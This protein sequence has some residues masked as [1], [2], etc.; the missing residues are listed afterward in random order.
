MHTEDG[1]TGVGWTDAVP[2]AFAITSN[3]EPRQTS[4]ARVVP[5]GIKPILL[6]QDV[7]ATEVLWQQML[8]L[9]YR[10]G[11]ASSGWS[12]S[13]ILASIAATDMALWDAKSKAAG[14]PVWKMLGA[15]ESAIDCY[16]AGGYYRDGKTTQNLADE[17]GRYAEQGFKA[18]KIRV[19]GR[20]IGEDVERVAAVRD[21][22]GA[23]VS[24]MIDANDAYDSETA[25]GAASRYE[26]HDIFWMEEPTRWYEGVDATKRVA[27]R[28]NIPIAGGE[29]AESRWEA[30]ELVDRAGLTFMQF[31]GMKTG[32]PTEW[33]KVAAICGTA[34][35]QMAPH[36]GPAIHAHLVA[37]IP[38]G[39]LVE[40]FADPSRYDEDEL[41]WIRWDKQREAFASYP[42]IKDGR[43]LLTEAPGWGVDFDEDVAGRRRVMAK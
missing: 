39:T 28:I 26:P 13:Q 33:M 29:K 24:L 8:A 41:Q 34:G 18:I 22:I 11:W 32:G 1:L 15:G 14:V 7:L 31:D 38:N 20:D 17:C 36:H 4:A 43:M 37:A 5:D 12:R 9:T 35:L 27:A 2:G 40:V 16:I 6:G 10:K 25:I 21:A 23:D 30:A 19:G 42:A 3:G